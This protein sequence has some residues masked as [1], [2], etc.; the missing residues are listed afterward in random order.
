MVAKSSFNSFAEVFL[1]YTMENKDVSSANSLESD[2]SSFDKS[3]IY[4]EK[5]KGQRIEP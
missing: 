3:L 5:I 2:D 4:I 1:S